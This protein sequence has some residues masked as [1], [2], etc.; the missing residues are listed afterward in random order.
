MK[1]EKIYVI[2]IIIFILIG[3]YYYYSSI[4]YIPKVI[5]KVYIQHN[6]T[7][8]DKL[9]PHIEESHRSWINLN[10]GYT[11][12][13]WSLNDCREYLTNN[14]PD[15]YLKTF[16]SI[17]PYSA[18]CDFFRYCIIYNEGGWYS[19]WK[20]VC[21]VDNLLD[22][23]SYS[24]F[25]YF[26]DRGNPYVTTNK[27]VAVAFFGSIKKH[28]ILKDAI[29]T[30]ISNT[31]KKYY[32][33]DVLDVTGPCLFG[34]VL[35]MYDIQSYGEYNHTESKGG[36]YYHILFGKIIQHKC[37]KC[38]QDQYWDNGNNYEDLWYSNK[39]YG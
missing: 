37:D 13:Y 4:N 20:Q 29:D 21:L 36:Y 24:D 1:N 3:C 16:D 18:K 32:G 7:I 11:I 39:F 2:I 14:F 31:D 8:P 15:K 10:P 28:P 6:G 35:K 26:Y 5:H 17:K 9:D 19:D 22:K 12:K 34:R 38:R 27:C 25:I 23:L 33:N 30:I